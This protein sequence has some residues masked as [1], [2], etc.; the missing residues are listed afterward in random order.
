LGQIGGAGAASDPTVLF[1]LAS[2][3]AIYVEAGAGSV[4]GTS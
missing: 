1:T 4:A 2:T 3:V